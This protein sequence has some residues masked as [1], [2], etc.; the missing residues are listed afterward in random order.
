MMIP[1]DFNPLGLSEKRPM[2]ALTVNAIIDSTVKIIVFNGSPTTSGLHYRRNVSDSWK[3]YSIDTELSIKRGQYIQ[4]MNTADTLNS[5]GNTVRF[6]MTGLTSV[7]GDIMSMLNYASQ[8]KQYC[9]SYLLH[10]NSYSLYSCRDLVLS[11]PAA[12]Y[13]CYMMLLGSNFN[14]HKCM[15]SLPCPPE[16]IACYQYIFNNCQRLEEM[17]ILPENF[18]AWSYIGA[19][20]GCGIYLTNGMK[21]V[22]LH[23]EVKGKSACYRQ[24]LQGAK[25]NR[26]EVDFTEWDPSTDDDFNPTGNWVYGIS[27]SGVFVKPQ[28]LPT[29]FGVSRIPSGWT[30]VDK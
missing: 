19:F 5:N 24:M 26:I 6:R 23:G 29:E 9:F 8:C 10:G 4:F 21:T 17:P 14:L 16:N 27:T 28:Q 20:A 22:P 12:V 7:C 3:P 18:T 2:D 30:V 15:K 25:I 1:Y 13:G 11:G